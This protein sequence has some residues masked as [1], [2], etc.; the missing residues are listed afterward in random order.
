M[1][2]INYL[3]Q[4]KKSFYSL[5]RNPIVL[6]PDISVV[7]IA[8]FLTLGALSIT[9]IPSL[10]NQA[11][12]IEAESELPAL[13]SSFIKTNIVKLS[14]T[15]ISF[16]FAMFVIGTG[17]IAMRFSII[18]D[19]TKNKKPTIRDAW[20]S[21]R[22]YFW[23]IVGIRVL[24]FLIYAACFVAA[25]LV[26]ALLFAVTKVGAAVIALIV[27][28]VALLIATLG[29]Y[30]KFPLLY[31]KNLSASQAIASSFRFFFANKCFVISI[32]AII[33]LTLVV[34]QSIINIVGAVSGVFSLGIKFI[35]GIV[36][37]IATVFTTLYLFQTFEH[38][39]KTESKHP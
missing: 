36:L 22:K 6:V 23:R 25:M 26:F 18:N 32:I 27:L 4:Y 3:E 21:S 12:A 31:K 13:F 5:I 10:L 19:I 11:A 34:L 35:G 15:I 16:L 38:Y 17:T 8:I 2:R 33:V 24:T 9:G 7:V 37:L 30:M 29:Q 1:I 20:V 14:V 39:K 28:V